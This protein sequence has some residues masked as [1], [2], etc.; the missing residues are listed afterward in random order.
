MSDLTLLRSFLAVYRSGSVSAAA[1]HLSLAQPTVTTH[2][3]SLEAELGR[4]L[5]TRRPRGVEPRRAA[6][7]L[8]SAVSQ[9]LDAL[10]EVLFGEVMGRSRRGG[11][12]YI[13]GPSEYLGSVVIPALAPLVSRGVRVRAMLDINEPVLESL[14]E[15]ELDLALLTEAP[16]DPAIEVTSQQSEEYVL[17][18]SP[19]RAARIGDVGEGSAGAEHLLDEPVLAYSE[20]LPLVRQ[21][22]RE[23]FDQ[24][25]VGGP[26]VIANSLPVLAALAA[27]GVG[28]TVLPRHAV[29]AQLAAGQLAVVHVPVTPPRNT[30]YLAWRAGSLAHP[31]I[32][33]AR[34]LLDASAR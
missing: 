5:F 15:G 8:A 21:Y 1:Q 33:T 14:M 3:Q 4:K 18:A 29:A 6:D 30:L 32:R 26:A 24:Q 9:H 22:W 11:V 27:Q 31:S 7:E 25:L 16:N 20:E 17:V 19:E 12:L 13:G 28:I 10:D 2:I 34:E 23:V